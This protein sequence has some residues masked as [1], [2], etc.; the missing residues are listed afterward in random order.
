[1]TGAFDV[2]AEPAR[3]R[4]LDLLL[5]S[6]PVRTCSDAKFGRHE[7]LGRPCLLFHIERCS[8]PCVGQVDAEHYQEL[9]SDLMAFLSG[10]TDPLVGRMEAAM[11]EAAAATDYERA[12]RL[13]DQLV[14][15]RKA[16]SAQQM[17]SERAEDIDVLGFADAELEAAV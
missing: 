7:R 4:L 15:V 8:G 13:R 2:V 16:A 14:S 10:D 3:R 5:R 11:R 12:A 6:F 17:V 1:M 9:V